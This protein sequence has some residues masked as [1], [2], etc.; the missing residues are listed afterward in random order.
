MAYTKTDWVEYETLVSADNLNKIENQLECITSTVEINEM[1]LQSTEAK[2]KAVEKNL[3][4]VAETIVSTRE[5]IDTQIAGQLNRLKKQNDKQSKEI[6][7]LKLKQEASDRIEGGTVFADNMAGNR[8]G[9]EFDSKLSE[10]VLFEDGSLT[11]N[12]DS[13][14][15]HNVNNSVVVKNLS[16]DVSFNG[17]RKL[18]CLDNG[19]LICIFMTN[20]EWNLYKTIN[21]GKS[22]T[23]IYGLTSSMLHDTC[24]QTDGTYIYVLYCQNNEDVSYCVLTENGDLLD[25]GHIQTEQIELATCSLAI[26]PEGTEL[27]ACWEGKDRNVRFPCV[28]YAYGTIDEDGSVDWDNV[29]YLIDDRI[30]YSSPSIV[31]N[32]NN[33]PVICCIHENALCVFSFERSFPNDPVT[34]FENGHASYPS[35]IFVPKSVNGLENG[36]IWVA[37]HYN[38]AYGLKGIRVSYSDDNGATWT[39]T[40]KI[41]SGNASGTL[42]SIT[43]NKNNEIFVTWHGGSSDKLIKWKDG[44]WGEVEDKNH[45]LGNF[46]STL[47][48]TKWNINFTK[49]LLI[50]ESSNSLYFI[51]SWTSG[52]Y[53]PTTEATAV[54]KLPSTDYV[55]MFVQK[56]GNVNIEATINDIPME[57]LLENNE[58]QFSKALDAE[59]PVTLK[60]SLSRKTLQTVITI[61]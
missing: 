18:V 22:W 57:S 59:A 61:K 21:N 33:D 24:I 53:I 41:L 37:W 31:L 1:A 44:V 36:R 14:V 43:A 6:A 23:N 48:D 19:T 42:P 8:F 38:N 15:E 47:Y 20:T 51:G 29:D 46:P 7:Y 5:E 27:Y 11:M 13:K 35:V 45:I 4:T 39:N 12:Y 17:G 10:N 30:P 50:S 2:V 58:Y 54:Y 49:P 26:N 28:Q 34:I 25:S 16:Y 9:I 55:G 32:A 40:E 3:Q 56:E 60:L 52:G